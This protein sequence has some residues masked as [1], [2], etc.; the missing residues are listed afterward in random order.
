MGWGSIP[1]LPLTGR[2]TLGKLL[3]AC[4]SVSSFVKGDGS[5]G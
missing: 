1:L 5:V 3:K 4:T 2:V